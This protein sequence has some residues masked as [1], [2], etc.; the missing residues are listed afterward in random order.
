MNIQMSSTVYT[1]Y[2]SDREDILVTLYNLT[3]LCALANRSLSYKGLLKQKGK[4]VK[5]KPRE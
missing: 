2:G 5:L 4:K 3:Q 1:S